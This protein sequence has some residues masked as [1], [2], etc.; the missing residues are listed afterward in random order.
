V[1]VNNTFWTDLYEITV[2]SFLNIRS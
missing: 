1:I 2:P